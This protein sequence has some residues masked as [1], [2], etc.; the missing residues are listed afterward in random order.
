MPLFAW[1][2]THGLQ[3]VG[4]EGAILG[5]AN[6]QML[7][8]HLATLTVR[9]VFHLKDLHAHLSDATVARDASGPLSSAA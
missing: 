9:G 6:P 8:R 5:T 1:T 4:S 3:R 2:V 7:V